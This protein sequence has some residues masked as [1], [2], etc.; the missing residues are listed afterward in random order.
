MSIGRTKEEQEL[1]ALLSRTLVQ[2]EVVEPMSKIGWGH[3]APPPPDYSDNPKAEGA[4][5]PAQ[6]PAAQPQSGLPAP[7]AGAPPAAVPTAKADTLSADDLVAAFEALRDPQTG[8]IAGKYKTIPEAL[9]GA[10]HLANM[11]KQAFQE[12][13]AALARPA[14]AVQLSPQPAVTPTAAPIPEPVTLAAS[15][16]KLK[17]AQERLDAVLSRVDD[18][19]GVVDGET[20]RAHTNAMRELAD[21][22]A[23]VRVQEIQHTQRA[24]EVAERD[25]W[26]AVDDFMQKNHPDSLSHSVE[27]GLHIQADPV[28]Q[29]AVG[30]LVAQGKE[31]QASVLAWNSYQRAVTSGVAAVERT[32]AENK[33]ADLAAKEQVRKELLE[34]AR[35]DAGV[36]Q[37]SSGGGVHMNEDAGAPSRDEMAQ[38]VA[39]MRNEGEGLGMGAATRFRHLLIGRHL[40]PSIFGGR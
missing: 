23:E 5:A 27:I 7:N 19:E 25:R 30:A 37:G 11:A 26:L 1:T 32:N 40:D 14:A 36:V 15:R 10:G 35:R 29:E 8:L 4:P 12:R 18:N 2:K 21:V 24:S 3:A 20:L 38:V 33:E 17:S 39:Q 9:K 16:A 22:Q 13:D 6:P 34:K 28:L 31:V